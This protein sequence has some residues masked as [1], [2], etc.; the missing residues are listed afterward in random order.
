MKASEQINELATALAKAQATIPAV[1]KRGKSH[2]GKYATLDD[3]IVA[4]REPLAKNGLS[5]V[6][7]PAKSRDGVGL[8]T[9]LM[10]ESGQWLEETFTM[11]VPGGRMNEAQ[12]YGAALTYARRYSL[13]AL[14]G[15]VTEEDTDANVKQSASNGQP[16]VTE[17]RR[18]KLHALGNQVYGDDWDSKR[19]DMSAAFEVGS[20]TQWSAEQ[21]NKV[22]EGLQKR[23]N[24]MQQE[25][26][27]LFEEAK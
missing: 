24:E 18:R 4:V 5:F 17:A 8:T 15:T 12:A 14:V 16:V 13:S 23:A 9:R 3:L 22:I 27:E 2:T 1:P 6:Q 11:P 26:G 25:Q 20:S 10:H 7:L 19:A 21:V